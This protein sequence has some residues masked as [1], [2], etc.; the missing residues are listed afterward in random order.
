MTISLVKNN[1]LQEKNFEY[2]Q[3][4]VDIVEFYA[5]GE[6][7]YDGKPEEVTELIAGFINALEFLD[8]EF[9]IEENYEEP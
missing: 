2:G 9:T 5:N 3:S 7:M 6:L 8:L 4:S 1:N